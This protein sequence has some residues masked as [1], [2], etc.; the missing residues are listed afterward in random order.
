[1]GRGK[2]EGCLEKF[3]GKLGWSGL[4]VVGRRNFF[5]NSIVQALVVVVVFVFIV[6]VLLSPPPLLPLAFSLLW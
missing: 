2:P 5:Y 1:V 6:V 3:R 4:K